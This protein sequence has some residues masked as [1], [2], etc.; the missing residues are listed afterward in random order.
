MEDSFHLQAQH[1]LHDRFAASCTEVIS[2]KTGNSF[3]VRLR[4][5]KTSSL[6]AYYG[7]LIDESYIFYSPDVRQYVHACFT[8]PFFMPP[9]EGY[10]AEISFS[11]PLAFALRDCVTDG[12]IKTERWVSEGGPYEVTGDDY[13]AT[14]SPISEA[15]MS[16]L[17]NG[18]AAVWKPIVEVGIA[19]IEFENI[20][21]IGRVYYGIPENQE[22]LPNPPDWQTETHMADRI[23]FCEFD[24]AADNL[25]EWISLH[26]HRTAL[27]Y[28]MQYF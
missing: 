8:Y 14:I 20:P 23:V 16:D 2:E 24:V 5:V 27:E 21:A 22:K 3:D 26:Y 13:N 11:L 6:A 15:I 18:L 17:L 28:L 10:A 7:T 19:R 12:N 1:E 25:R 4:D 9:I